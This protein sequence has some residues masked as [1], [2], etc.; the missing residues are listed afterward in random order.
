MPGRTLLVAG[1]GVRHPQV[2]EIQRS[3]LLAAAIRA[4]EELGYTQ[5]TVAH[6]TRRAR[7]SRRT[8][9]ELF[10]NRE[11]CLIAALESVVDGIRGEVAAAGLEGLSWRERL[12]GG[13]WAILSFFDHEPV[14]ARVC[15]VQALRGS[16]SV[17]ERREEILA[18]LA[19]VIDEGRGEGARGVACPPS[20]AEGLVGAGF[21]LVYSRLLRGEREPLTGLIGDLMGMIVLPYM[22]PAAARREQSRPVPGLPGSAPARRGA[23]KSA[24]AQGQAQA[25]AQG[26]PLAGIPMRLTYR[27]VRVLEVIA[28]HPG[29]SNRGVG[30]QAG[31]S[32]QGQISKLLARLERLGLASNTGEGHLKGE[33]N[34]WTLTPTGR[35]VAQTIRIH[36]HEEAA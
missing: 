31:V 36:T 35:R 17:L 16:Q 34:A 1:E 11:E 32:D 24:N 25:H 15:V 12:R 28:A 6:I 22:G 27:T 3:R 10:A 29:V 23:S 19:A 30:E 18:G 5:A 7:V 33:P 21:A 4:V 26:D 20:T 14:L 13:L 2:A 9:Y 8:F